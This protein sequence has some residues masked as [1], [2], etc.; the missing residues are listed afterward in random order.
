MYFYRKITKSLK[1]RTTFMKKIIFLFVL[2]T[3][4]SKAQNDTIT[5]FAYADNN[6]NCLYEPGMGE[7]PLINYCFNFDYRFPTLNVQSNTKA[8]DNNG[9]VKFAATGA[10]TPASNTL[11]INSMVGSYSGCN[12][13]ATNYAYNATYSVGVVSPFGFKQAVITGVNFDAQGSSIASMPG[14]ISYCIGK[15]YITPFFAG[16]NYVDNMPFFLPLDLTVSGGSTNNQLALAF[17]SYGPNCTVNLG[18]GPVN[19]TN[20]ELSTTGIY[21]VS[22]SGSYTNTFVLVV[23]SCSTNS[24]NVFVDCNANCIKDITEYNSSD[25]VISSTN[26]TYSTTVIPD[27]NGNYSILS[28]YSATQYSLTITPN[29]DFNLA[30][31][32]PSLSTYYSNYNNLVS[33]NSV[34]NQTAANNINYSSYLEHPYG[35]SSVPGGNFKFNSYYYVA[36]PDYCSLVNNSGTYYVKLDPSVQFVS[37]DPNTPN[38]TAIYP[39]AAGDSIVWSITDLRQMAMNLGGHQFVLNLMM[40]VTATIGNNYCFKTGVISQVTETT[41]ADNTAN[42]CWLIGGP[43]D[44]N[45]IEV[46]PKGTG[47]QGYIPVN[48]TELLYTIHFQNVGTAPAIDVRIKN[49]LDADLEKSSLTVIGSSFPVQTNIDA[50]G[51]V[52]FLFDNILLADSTNDEPN[53]HGFVTYKI[54]LKPSLSVGT[55]INSTASIYF[56]YN[57][58]I[59]TNTTLNTLQAATGIQNLNSGSFELYPNPSNG[60]VTVN[61]SNLI[62]KI[63]VINV[64]GE[65][66]KSITAD[67]KHVIVD[68]TDLK[69]NVYFLQLTDEKNQT[70]IKKIVKE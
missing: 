12:N 6:N 11:T 44:P 59:I 14:A 37:V 40:K 30:C 58:P 63:M 21:T 54:N 29:T 38:Y 45:Y 69:S 70:I 31:S 32:T 34:L 62:S 50:N 47:T 65:V 46:T 57:A 8:T 9:F 52:T 7:H 1:T 18:G 17:F 26:G 25:E 22:F 33:F 20:I 13:V 15:T 16:F 60:I 55:Q 48:T 67:S 2:I 56:D 27:Y 35:G 36:K 39:S 53:S 61:S 41:F 10:M 42:A 64:L 4:L 28:P 66:V 49:P 24:A 23:D 3:T 5:F 68:I 43:Y 19:F 51:L